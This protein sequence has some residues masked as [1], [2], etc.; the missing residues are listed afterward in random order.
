MNFESLAKA[1]KSILLDRNDPNVLMKNMDME[2]RE[3]LMRAIEL[4]KAKL[5]YHH[6]GDSKETIARR[7]IQDAKTS[8]KNKDK[9]HARANLDAAK[10]AMG[11]SRMATDKEKPKDGKLIEF[12]ASKNFAD[13]DQTKTVS[14]PKKMAKGDYDGRDFNSKQ[15]I[16]NNAERKSN[17]IAGGSNTGIKAMPHIKQYGGSGANAAGRQAKIDKQKSAKNHVEYTHIHPETGEST[18]VK[19]S[20]RKLKNYQRRMAEIKMNQEKGKKNG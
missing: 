4:V 9:A 6:Y 20:P 14:V 13:K 15:D 2:E 17:N 1:I 10:D 7:F 3:V 11:Y 5:A 8:V 16:A 12:P 19:M 18:T